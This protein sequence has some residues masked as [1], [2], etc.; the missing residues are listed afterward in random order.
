MRLLYAPSK[1]HRQDTN[2][3]MRS[4]PW[5]SATHLYSILKIN[6]N[7]TCVSAVEP[8]TS[9]AQEKRGHYTPCFCGGVLIYST[10]DTAD[11]IHVFP[12]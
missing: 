4:P 12:L 6:I 8:P 11:G 7:D 3:S 5:T 2:K 1:Y 9:K 10:Q